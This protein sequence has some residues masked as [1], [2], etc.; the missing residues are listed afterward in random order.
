MTQHIGTETN[1]AG[2]ISQAQG[3]LTQA[4]ACYRAPDAYAKLERFTVEQAS[5]D[6][7]TVRIQRLAV[8][9]VLR[10]CRFPS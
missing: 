8:R 4:L 9:R 3:L 10:M 6:W 7:G 2:L 1:P 5:I